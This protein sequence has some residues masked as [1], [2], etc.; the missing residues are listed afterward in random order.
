MHDKVLVSNLGF[1]NAKHYVRTGTILANSKL[2]FTSVVQLMEAW[3]QKRKASAVHESSLIGIDTIL[4][5]NENMRLLYD[6]YIRCVER[7]ING[8][9]LMLLWKLMRP[10]FQSGSIIEEDWWVP[11]Q[12]SKV[13][14]SAQI[15]GHLGEL[16]ELQAMKAEE[17][18][19]SALLFSWS[20]E[21]LKYLTNL[22]L[23][24]LDQ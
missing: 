19:E 10:N 5:F 11:P 1:G 14:S 21:Q 4:A 23:S 20:R 24:I 15:S 9:G 7:H 12:R 17:S 8:G 3:I 13:S 16:S 22:H 6:S 18:E 2:P